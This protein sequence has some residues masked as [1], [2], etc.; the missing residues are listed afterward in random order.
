MF[1]ARFHLVSPCFT[2]I[3][4]CRR[5]DKTGSSPLLLRFAR[6]F[7]RVTT[8]SDFPQPP[9]TFQ[10]M[11][12]LEDLTCI[13]VSFGGLA[14]LF[15]FRTFL[16]HHISQKFS[17]YQVLLLTLQVQVDRGASRSGWGWLGAHWEASNTGR[18]TENAWDSRRRFT[19]HR[20]NMGITWGLLYSQVWLIV[21]RRKSNVTQTVGFTT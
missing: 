13:A 15:F 4:L 6:F 10:E 11:Q 7:Q 20:D 16:L 5:V 19:I 17:K 12:P 9:F 3:R 14:F 1:F 21:F 2:V 18:V 8:R